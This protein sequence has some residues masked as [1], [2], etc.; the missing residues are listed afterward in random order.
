VLR[1]GPAEERRVARP[2]ETRESFRIIAGQVVGPVEERRAVSA[3]PCQ[4]QPEPP[5]DVGS[6]SKGYPGQYQG[7]GARP[8]PRSRVMVVGTSGSDGSDG[9]AVGR[10][11][12]GI[13]WGSGNDGRGGVV[14][15]GHAPLSRA[16][17]A[18]P[19]VR[20]GPA[21][22]TSRGRT[23]RCGL[24]PGRRSTPMA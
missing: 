2:A 8:L 15:Q 1:A 9:L 16:G 6:L 5:Q 4:Q 17:R 20:R 24:R 11:L 7:Y 13:G 12:A 10:K 3:P 21:R 18:A 23:R 19:C 22:P 14:D